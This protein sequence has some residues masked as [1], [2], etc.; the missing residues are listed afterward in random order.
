MIDLANSNDRKKDINASNVIKN[1]DIYYIIAKMEHCSYLLIQHGNNSL[2][3]NEQ[4]FVLID[5]VLET[6]RDN[7]LDVPVVAAYYYAY[8]LLLHQQ[9]CSEENYLKLKTVLKENGG[10]FSHSSL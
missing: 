8:A 10:Q 9:E 7:Y 4:S 3:N 1:L 2:R 6:A 5:K